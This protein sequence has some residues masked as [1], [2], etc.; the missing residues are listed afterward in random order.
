[1]KVCKADNNIQRKNGI[2]CKM[3][4]IPIDSHALNMALGEINGRYP[5][6]GY[7]VNRKVSELVY[8]QSGS[9]SLT[10]GSKTISFSKG[11]SLL[12]EPNEYFYWQG[13]FS[14]VIACS[15]AFT[16]EQHEYI[17]TISKENL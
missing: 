5:E 9:G 4:E 3:T 1:M 8:I 11:D 6:T 16:V 7:A 2:H 13:S 12:I 14:T 10:V 15:P 17:E